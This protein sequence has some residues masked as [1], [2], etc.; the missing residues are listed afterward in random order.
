MKNI[1]PNCGKNIT[2]EESNYYDMIFCPNCNEQLFV[3]DGKIDEF[4]HKKRKLEFKD[5]YCFEQED[6][7]NIINQMFNIDPED[8]STVYN[9][10]LISANVISN[11][12]YMKNYAIYYSGIKAL[13]VLIRSDNYGKIIQYKILF[14]DLDILDKIITS[15]Q[16]IKNQKMYNYYENNLDKTIN[17]LYI[18][19]VFY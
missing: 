14:I 18:I 5:I 6:I 9:D 12:L 15:Y 8:Y 11:N 17:V 16:K 10:F 4:Y 7:F 19:S 2:V 13:N 1:C 3:P